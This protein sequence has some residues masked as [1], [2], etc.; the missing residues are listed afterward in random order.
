MGVRRVTLPALLLSVALLF[1]PLALGGQESDATATLTGTVRS[2]TTGEPLRQ[3]SVVLRTSGRR[4]FTDAA[5][6][7][8]L[9]GVS[10]GADVLQVKLIGFADESVPLGLAAD[11]VTRV[12]LLLSE[13]VLRLE[14]IEVTVRR[15]PGDR[16]AGFRQRRRTGP[17]VFIGP[18]QIA[19]SHAVRSSDLLRT[20]PGIR[21]G[22]SRA[23]RTS[24][25]VQ[26][27]QRICRPFI[28]LDG[29]PARDYPIDALSPD[30]L[31]GVEIYRGT[32]ET[33]ARFSFRGGQCATLVIWTR[34]GRSGER[35][36]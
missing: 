33:P 25:T 22:A 18:D 8:T 28:Y 1:W 2:A 35:E 14:E 24:I 30:D 31:L 20:V 11:H 36:R 21:V 16:L 32:S 3:A 9:R 12:E 10:P 17:G 6:R 19:E 26:R 15:T 34:E 29:L 4:T 5:G 7:F 27:G 23:G 13:T